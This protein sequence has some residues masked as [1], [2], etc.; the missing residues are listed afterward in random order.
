[1]SKCKMLIK[2]RKSGKY[3]G[4]IKVCNWNTSYEQQHELQMHGSNPE[5]HSF[6]IFKNML[7]FFM[8][9]WKCKISMKIRKSGKY[10]GWMKACN[11]NRSYRQQQEFSNT[12]IKQENTLHFSFQ[13]YVDIFSW[14]LKMWIFDK[15]PEI[16]KICWTCIHF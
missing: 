10:I 16:M 2:I 5:V 3:F 11:W 7:T 1:M 8:K 15:N 14:N 9:I 4:W 13:K 12:G 6:L